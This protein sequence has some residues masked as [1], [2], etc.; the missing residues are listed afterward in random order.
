M[1]TSKPF[2][3][4]SL[5]PRDSDFSHTQPFDIPTQ[6]AGLE[7][8]V[9]SDNIDLDAIQKALEGKPEKTSAP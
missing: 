5:T 1:S 8:F 2:F 3:H 7:G 6:P 9:S 4:D